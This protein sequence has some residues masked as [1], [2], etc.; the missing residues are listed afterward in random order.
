MAL[1][2]VAVGEVVKA[3]TMNA[4]ID[5][6]NGANGRAIFT[7]NGTWTLPDGVQR[8][9]VTL[10]GGGGRGHASVSVGF[11]G[12]AYD[13]AG[14]EGGDAPMISGVFTGYDAGTSFAIDIG[15]GGTSSVPTG[16]TTSFGT[17]GLTSAGGQL[18]ANSTG[19]W[20]NA[21]VPKGSPGAATF[22]SGFP[23]FFHSNDILC[24][25]V[26]HFGKIRG[27]GMGGRGGPGFSGYGGT[28]EALHSPGPEDG[29][30]GVCIIEW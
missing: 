11:G 17:T 7:T 21:S 24:R 18:A 3:S 23:H 29:S 20:D 22:P 12:E 19:T 9:K 5:F 16:G 6:V 30:P 2:N 28:H 1:E 10:C 25:Y 14:G 4:V 26:F 13:L 8:F 27:Y 15:V